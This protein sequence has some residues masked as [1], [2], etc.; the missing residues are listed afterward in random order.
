[1]QQRLSSRHSTYAALTSII[2]CSMACQTIQCKRYNSHRMLLHRKSSFQTYY[3]SP[4]ETALASYSWKAGVQAHMS[5]AEVAGWINT[6]LSSFR[7]SI[8]CRHWPP[9]APICIWEDMC[10]STHTHTTASVSEVSLLPVLVCGK[11]CHHI[12]VG[13]WIIDI[14]NK[15][16][17][18]ICS[19][20]TLPFCIAT[21][22]FCAP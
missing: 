4:T 13:T 20:C 12:C 3:S 22:W 17:R 16:W 14:S 1:M 5:S 2:H 8:Y 7:H 10:C 9:S 19:G 21:K 15:H 11:L 6:D 18:D